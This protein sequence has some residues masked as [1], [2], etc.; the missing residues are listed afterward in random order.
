MDNGQEHEGNDVLVSILYAR[1][2]LPA[3]KREFSGEER[4]R[5]PFTLR[6]RI[7]PILQSK[8]IISEA[9][10]SVKSNIREIS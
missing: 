1:E 10:S 4:I 5:I 7:K 2:D 6:L 3:F 9:S 8:V